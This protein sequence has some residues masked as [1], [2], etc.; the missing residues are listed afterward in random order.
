M[1]VPK[2]HITVEQLLAENKACV[3][4]KIREEE[5]MPLPLFPLDPDHQWKHAKFPENFVLEIPMGKVFGR[6]GV[7]ITPDNK[8]IKETGFEWTRP[9]EKHT[10]FEIESMPELTYVDLTVAVI[11]AQ[12]PANYYHWMLEIVPRIKMLR[13]SKV[14]FDKL[15]VPYL[16][17]NFQW[18]SLGKLGFTEKDLIFGYQDVYIQAARVV[19]P[20]LVNYKCSTNPPWAIRF[21]RDVFLPGD[22]NGLPQKKRLYISRKDVTTDWARRYIINAG[23]VW[24]YLQSKGFDKVV[25]EDLPLEE[26]VK[27][28]NS[29]EIVLGPHGAGLANLVFCRP[30]T[31]VF[32]FFHPELL[33][34]AYWFLSD[35]L[36]LEHHCLTTSLDELTPA[37]KEQGD[38]FIP[39]KT[40]ED[41][42]RLVETN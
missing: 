27:L 21:L 36:K 6:H 13:D 30:G 29:A 9:I 38:I 32:E 11:A 28:F 41:T 25:L 39:V 12:A 15:Y 35:Q 2:T 1:S 17:F 7:V 5:T 18:E 37:Q 3:Y 34:Q 23:E 16:R 20:S 4:H 33:D 14:R 24:A 40:L 10:V 19:A 8:I 42:L 26:Q 22:N 31:K